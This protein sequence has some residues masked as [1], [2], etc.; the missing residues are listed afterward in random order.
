MAG[1]AMRRQMAN[2]ARPEP[3]R[4]MLSWV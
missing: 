1:I 3:E 4:A 2:I